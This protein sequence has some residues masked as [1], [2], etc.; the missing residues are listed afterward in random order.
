MVGISHFIF[1]FMECARTWPFPWPYGERRRS[2][3]ASLR[4]QKGRIS[5]HNP[6]WSWS[7]V[8]RHMTVTSNDRSPKSGDEDQSCWSMVLEFG[9]KGETVIIKTCMVYRL[10]SLDSSLQ[11]EWWFIPIQMKVLVDT[12]VYRHADCRYK[13]SGCDCRSVGWLK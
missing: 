9:D 7:F 12:S 6:S 11:R 2:E 8:F 13:Q 4:H 10:S 3:Q 1:R 5:E